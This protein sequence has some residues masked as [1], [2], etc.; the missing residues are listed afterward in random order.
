V[1]YDY[2]ERADPSKGHQNPKRNLGVATHFSDIT[3]LKFGKKL[4]YILCILT[5]S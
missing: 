2:V 3:E 1:V 4:P 5:L